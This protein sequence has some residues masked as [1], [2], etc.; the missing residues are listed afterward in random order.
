MIKQAFS[1]MPEVSLLAFRG[2]N[3]LVDLHEMQS[4][5]RYVLSAS[6]RN[7][8]HGVWPTADGCD[9]PSARSHSCTSFRRDDARP[10]SWA[11][12]SASASNSIFIENRTHAAA[13]GSPQFTSNTT[14]LCQP[15]AG[16]T[17]WS[18]SLGPQVFGSYSCTGCIRL[19]HRI[20]DAPRF[21]H[22]VFSRKQGRRLRPYASSST[23][24]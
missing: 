5:P 10:P 23:R 19:Q 24:S 17:V 12:V 8:S 7:M 4:F 13:G 20:D 21:F 3:T 16:E 18:T 6:A 11:T 22:I 2:R 1:Q 9:K 15:P 14:G